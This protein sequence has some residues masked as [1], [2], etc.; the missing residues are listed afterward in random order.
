[1]ADLYRL[2]FILNGIIPRA[3]NLAVQ[4]LDDGGRLAVV[5]DG[6]RVPRGPYFHDVRDTGGVALVGNWL[7]L[8]KE[9]GVSGVL[10]SQDCCRW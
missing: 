7:E 2:A 8:K 9:E 5:V 4:D 10:D 3:L 6:R 1:M